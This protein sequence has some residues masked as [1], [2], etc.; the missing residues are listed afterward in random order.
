MGNSSKLI[1]P[2]QKQCKLSVF[3]VDF[4]HLSTWNTFLLIISSFHVN[5]ANMLFQEMLK[6]LFMFPGLQVNYENSLNIQ[7]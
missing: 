2:T 6:K 1:R 7:N 4:K 5:V 3:N